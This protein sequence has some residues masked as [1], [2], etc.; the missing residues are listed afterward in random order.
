[1]WSKDGISYNTLS[2]A[3]LSSP[4]I[5]PTT[6]GF[7]FVD[8]GAYLI[9]IIAINAIGF[10]NPSIPLS[11]TYYSVPQAP[12]NLAVSV[13]LDQQANQIVSI[14]FSQIPSANPVTNYSWSKDGTNYTSL[15][16]A[17]LSSP[18]IIP[19]TE[20]IKGTSY[21]FSLKAI[22]NR[23]E[24]S[25]SF[26]SISTNIRPS[27][28]ALLSTNAKK[29]IYESYNYSLQNLVTS[30]L[31][32]LKKLQDAEYTLEQL[33]QHFTT[34]ELIQSR[35]YLGKEL[36]EQGL[37]EHGIVFIMFI[38]VFG[39]SNKI[40][41]SYSLNEEDIEEQRSINLIHGYFFEQLLSR[42][43]I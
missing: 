26:Q 40:L 10:S 1:M 4:I 37:I 6:S 42:K 15:S 23:G 29:P 33:K 12:T 30:A 27:L 32:N 3:D 7:G 18:I 9:R 13:D 34:N 39:E 31:F 25:A 43:A 8:G 21:R 11:Y 20:L 28:A 17:D 41:Y 22:N 14:S 35:A 16:P 38:I 36:K 5:I 19:N 24:S 2:P